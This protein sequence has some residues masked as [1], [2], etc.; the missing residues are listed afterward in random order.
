ME[1]Q[2]K[3]IGALPEASGT[4]KAGKPWRKRTYVLETQEQYPKKLAFDLLGDRIDRFAPKVD[5]YVKVSFG[6]NSR[7][8]NGKWFTNATAWNVERPQSAFSQQPQQ[9]VQQQ[10]TTQPPNSS[11]LPF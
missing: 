6:L 8:F 9:P 1:I 4:S 11:T 2:G 5:E 3:I 10:P 7:E